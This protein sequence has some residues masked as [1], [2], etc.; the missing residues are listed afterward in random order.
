[1]RSIDDEGAGGRR[2]RAAGRDIDDDRNGSGDHVADNVARCADQAAGRVKS[3]DDRRG[4]FFLGLID[5][6]RDLSCGGDADGT[7]NIDP[8]NAIARRGT[9]RAGCSGEYRETQEKSLKR[10]R[11]H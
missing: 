3:D 10:H 2:A 7:V 5:R 8:K 9:C 11:Y 1:M 4:A 6:A